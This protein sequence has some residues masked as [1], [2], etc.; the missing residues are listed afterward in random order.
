MLFLWDKQSTGY[1]ENKHMVPDYKLEG[2]IS[3]TRMCW[4]GGHCSTHWV[5]FAPCVG[6]CVKRSPLT[7]VTPVQFP[8][9]AI[10]E[11]SCALVFCCATRVFQTIRKNQTLSILA[12]LRGHNG[13][14]WLAAKV[15]LACLLLEHVVAESFAMQLLAANKDD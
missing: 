6:L 9:R 1:I 11:L 2:F 5:R 4:G 7:E 15:A 8:A 3:S 13:L 14:M 10:C 12:V